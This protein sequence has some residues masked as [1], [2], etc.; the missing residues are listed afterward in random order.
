MIFDF[1]CRALHNFIKDAGRL[2]VPKQFG[3]L[4]RGNPDVR[5]A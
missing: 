4:P 2:S 3:T 5:D 1:S